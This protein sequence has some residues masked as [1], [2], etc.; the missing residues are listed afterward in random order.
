MRV[1]IFGTMKVEFGGCSSPSNKV[2]RL[3][4]FRCHKRQDLATMLK[5]IR[6]VFVLA[7]LNVKTR[8]VILLPAT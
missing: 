4:N 2:H 6:E 7:F 1:D 8:Q 5:G 3:Y